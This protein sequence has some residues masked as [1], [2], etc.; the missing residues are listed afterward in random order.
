[1]QLM[2]SLWEQLPVPGR[3]QHGKKVCVLVGDFVEDYESWIV[4][5]ALQTY[6]LNVYTVCP[7]KNP[8]SSCQ[9]VIHFEIEGDQSYT[10][11][12]GH[13]LYINGIFQA[14]HL[15]NYDALYI[16]GGRCCERLAANSGV[17]RLVN[18]FIDAGK[19][20]AAMCHG[21]LVL[22]AADVVRG[23]R[24]ATIK[25]C[26][27]AVE[28]AGGIFVDA[29]EQEPCVKDGFLITAGDTPIPA[30]ARMARVL[31]QEL[32]IRFE[33]FNR[34]VLI[35]TGDFVEDLEAMGCFQI[36]KSCGFHVETCSPGRRQGQWVKTV[37]HVPSSKYNGELELEGHRFPITMDFNRVNPNDFHCLLIPGGRA[38]EYLQSEAKSLQL[39]R[40]FYS[41]G[42]V[43]GAFCH[44]VVVLG[45]A[46]ILSGKRVT[47]IPSVRPQLQFSGMSEFMEPSDPFTACSDGNVVTGVSYMGTPAFLHSCIEAMGCRI[48]EAA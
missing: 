9:G 45:T 31:A 32:G 48:P 6:G 24:I 39:V 42:K 21:A 3:T 22:C 40:D 46:G 27:A 25:E 16:P 12:R 2:K 8:G 47:S 30:N 7:D 4:I 17:L 13:E 20:V 11:K 36:M 33:N 14:A 10:E 38:H 37:C 18:S 43:V 23:R 28:S 41:A 1:M 29:M 5:Q 35:M 15:Q 19:P 34:R 44:G 26:K